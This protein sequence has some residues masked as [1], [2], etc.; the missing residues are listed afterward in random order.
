MRRREVGIAGLGIA[1]VLAGL[2]FNPST[3]ATLLGRNI[4]RFEH[5]LLVHAMELV[6]ILPGLFLVVRRKTLDPA[7]VMLAA[8]TLAVCG[9]LLL[10]V[11]L[12]LGGAT[13]DRELA[14]I[15]NV[16]VADPHLGWKPKPGVGRHFHKGLFDVSYAIGADGL[17]VMPAVGQPR[18]RVF[19]FGDSF[20]FGHGVADDATYS[21]LI[22]RRY[23]R[24]GIGMH[25]AGVMGYGMAQMYQRFLELESGIG[26]GD[27][28]VLAPLSEDL[29]R[30][31][32]TLAQRTRLLNVLHSEG[33][34]HEGNRRFYPDYR[35]GKLE[36]REIPQ[37]STWFERLRERAFNA[38]FSG[39]LFRTLAGGGA[40]RQR[41]VLASREMIQSMAERTAGRGA[42]FALVFLPRTEECAAGSYLQDVSELQHLDLMRHFPSAREAL[43]P[44]AFKGDGHWNEAGHRVAADALV[45]ALTVAGFL[46]LPITQEAAEAHVR[47]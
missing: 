9:G 47:K 38:P 34:A 3:V 40:S 42:R 32:E 28:V 43:D 37:A 1:L 36:F 5:R 2:A 26:P 45:A 46:P 10:A 13:I 22:A 11:D 44:L 24:S 25:N 23:L 18:S 12:W 6:L 31:Y 29:A 20:T 30:S 39:A 8:G 27:L 19:F 21:H 17:R 35:D 16:H 4:L 7:G 33:R 41:A 14:Y 15:D